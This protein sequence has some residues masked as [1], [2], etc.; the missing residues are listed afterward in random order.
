MLNLT[1]LVLLFAV[2]HMLNGTAAARETWVQSS[3][4]SAGTWYKMSVV[5]EGIYRIDYSVLKQLG[6]ANISNPRIYGNNFGQLSYYNDD[7]KP[8]DLEEA[9]MFSMRVITC[10]S[11]QKELTGGNTII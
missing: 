3:V 5:E 1:S 11:M 2:L 9:T 7:N 4:L 8:D 10:Y 6:M